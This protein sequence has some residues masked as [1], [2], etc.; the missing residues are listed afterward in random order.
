MKITFNEK[1]YSIK[2]GYKATVK[3]GIIKKLAKAENEKD[4]AEGFESIESL[5][6]ILPEL[7]VVG[8]Q[9]HHADEF[10]YN[11]DNNEGYN[12]KVDKAFDVLDK[13]LEDKEHS[14]IDLYN[15]LEQEL[16]NDSFLSSLFQRAIAEEQKAEETKQKKATTKKN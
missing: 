4:N 7:L 9:V 2:F 5:L 14:F 16:I 8:L 1:E 15:E 11:L 13:W 12:E 3:S 10:G 6:V